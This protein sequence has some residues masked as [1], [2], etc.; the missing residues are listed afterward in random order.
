[1]SARHAE[2][3]LDEFVR[4]LPKTETHLHFEGALSIELLRT[5]QPDVDLSSW[6]SEFKFGGFEHFLH[7]LL[8]GGDDHAEHGRPRHVR[9]HRV[10]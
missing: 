3:P 5:V 8:D 6:E 1:M 9:Q 7:D 4:L 10:G 2:L